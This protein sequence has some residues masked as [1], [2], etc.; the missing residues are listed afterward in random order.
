MHKTFLVWIEGF[1]EN[2]RNV[3]IFTNGNFEMFFLVGKI[4]IP[5]TIEIRGGKGYWHIDIKLI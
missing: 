5:I 4:L 1:L 3:A 2:N